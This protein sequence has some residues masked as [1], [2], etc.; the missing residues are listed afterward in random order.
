MSEVTITDP[1][2]YS[3]KDVDGSGR[4][5]LGQDY[6]GAEVRVCVEVVAEPGERALAAVDDIKNLSTADQVELATHMS[7]AALQALRG[8][9]CSPQTGTDDP[10]W[11][12]MD[13]ELQ[14]RAAAKAVVRN[15]VDQF[16]LDTGGDNDEKKMTE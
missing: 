12:D 10:D 8:A 13:L 6:A 3:E 4:I 15:Y 16:G 14:E 1:L 2:L 9:L 11:R 7:P 5:Y